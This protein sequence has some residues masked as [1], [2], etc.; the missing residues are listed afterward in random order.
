M[1][2][3]KVDI[4]Y[5]NELKQSMADMKKLMDLLRKAH[6]QNALAAEDDPGTEDDE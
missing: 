5:I 2:K 4:D 3:N 1:A 6:K